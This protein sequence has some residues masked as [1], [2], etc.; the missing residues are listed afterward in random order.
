[1]KD[2]SHGLALQFVR[3]APDRYTA[4]VSKAKRAG[5]I[6]IDYLRN[7]P[8]STA[9]ATWSPRRR[10]GAPVAVPL[11]WD[12]LDDDKQPVVSLRAVKPRLALPDPW[13]GFEAARRALT[14]AIRARVGAA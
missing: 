8:E 3:A 10:P 6:L 11:E 1:M 13:A 14:P 7:D 12:E 2:F 9:I 5:K 4:T